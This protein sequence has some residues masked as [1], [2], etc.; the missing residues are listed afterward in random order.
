[1]NIN[2]QSFLV[3]TQVGKTGV[4]VNYTIDLTNEPQNLGYIL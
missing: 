3:I 2:S 4:T 1:M